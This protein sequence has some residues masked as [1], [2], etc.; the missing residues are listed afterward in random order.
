MYANYN[1]FEIKMTKAQA[2]IASHQGS[3]DADVEYLLTLPT[4][5]RQ[6]KKISDDVLAA[7]LREY[8]AWSDEELQDRAANEARIIWLAA[9]DIKENWNEVNQ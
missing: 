1:S 6:L 5:K 3:C 4:I 7:E 8:G 9:G 2:E